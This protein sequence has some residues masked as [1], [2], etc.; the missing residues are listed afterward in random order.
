MTIEGKKKATKK[1]IMVGHAIIVQNLHIYEDFCK[2]R[3]GD[4]ASNKNS[5]HI[6]FTEEEED[7]DEDNHFCLYS[8]EE[9]MK[10]SVWYII[11]RIPL[12]QKYVISQ[13]FVF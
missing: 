8:R 4:M 11:Y 10:S 6:I 12:Y 2:K 7:E 9:E 3:R 13:G 5:Y 1:N